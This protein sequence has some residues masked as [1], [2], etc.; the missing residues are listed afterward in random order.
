MLVLRGNSWCS[1]IVLVFFKESKLYYTNSK[2]Y[3][4]NE[5]AKYRDVGK[6]AFLAEIP[7]YFGNG[8]R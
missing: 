5:S 6:L 4:L 8:A 2:D 7:V 3:T 1:A